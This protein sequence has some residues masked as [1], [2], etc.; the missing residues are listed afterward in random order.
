MFTLHI[1]ANYAGFLSAVQS[2]PPDIAHEVEQI[3]SAFS[4]SSIFHAIAYIAGADFTAKDNN[5]YVSHNWYTRIRKLPSVDT[6]LK[7][8]LNL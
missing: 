2:L 7:T 8:L 6:N 3:R 4:H 5:L 1:T